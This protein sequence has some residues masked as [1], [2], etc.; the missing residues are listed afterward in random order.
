MVSYSLL[1]FMHEIIFI[2]K[3]IHKNCSMKSWGR[4]NGPGILKNALCCLMCMTKQM[5][6]FVSVNKI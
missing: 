2:V 1:V 3:K 5:H 6:C 4:V